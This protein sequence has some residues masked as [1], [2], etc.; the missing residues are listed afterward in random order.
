MSNNKDALIARLKL[1]AQM[2]A[3]EARTA[4][5]TIAEI[6]QAVTGST[7]EPGNWHGARPVRDALALLRSDAVAL[8][9]LVAAGHVSQDLV[10]RARALPGAPNIP[11][12]GQGVTK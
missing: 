3:Q 4:N 5:A 12:P 11:S 8:R 6:Y 7:G 1:E 10:D 9:A 2:H